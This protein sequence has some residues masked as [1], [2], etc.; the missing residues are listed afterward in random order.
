MSC[1][2]DDNNGII[3]TSWSGS[4]SQTINGDGI[5]KETTTIFFSPDKTN[6][7]FTVTLSWKPEGEVTYE[8][9]KTKYY[10]HTYRYEHPNVY[11][12]CNCDYNEEYG[13][14]TGVFDG[15]KFTIAKHDC[16]WETASSINCLKK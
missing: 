5:Y 6:A 13:Q 14:L 2:K 1:S 16:L 3:N 8:D 7:E 15:N 11:F 9:L 4:N 12:N 10:K